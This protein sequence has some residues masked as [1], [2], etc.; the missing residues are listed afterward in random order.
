MFLQKTQLSIKDKKELGR[1]KTRLF[2][3]QSKI[4]SCSVLSGYYGSKKFELIPKLNN[5]KQ[6]KVILVLEKK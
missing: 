6:S 4:N 5:F 2:F 1:F 3:A